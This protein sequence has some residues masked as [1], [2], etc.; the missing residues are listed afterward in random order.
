MQEELAGVNG[1]I[2]EDTSQFDA[3]TYQEEYT[4]TRR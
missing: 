4:K 1:G 2:Y 3:R